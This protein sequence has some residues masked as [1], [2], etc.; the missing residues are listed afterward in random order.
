MTDPTSHA[1]RVERAGC[2]LEGLS[3]GGAFGECFFVN[4][5]AV[6]ALTGSRTPPAAPWPFTDDTQMAL[7]VFATLRGHGHVESDYLAASFA[8]RYDDRRR[9][10]PSMRG[11][12][13]W[14]RLGVPWSVADPRLF[15]GSG[16]HGNGAAMRVAPL[17]AYFAD[18]LEAVVRE[19]EKSAAVT[20]AHPE[21]VAGAVA[22]AVAAA[23]AV[24][25]RA[26]GETCEGREFL[27]RILFHVPDS[28]VREKIRHA[29]NLAPGCSVYLAVAALGNGTQISAQ[30]T[31][32][33]ALWCA[34]QHLNDYEE[35][36][37]LTVRGLGDRD[38]TCAIVGGIVAA[39]TGIDGIPS[40]WR[41]AR[42][43][44][45]EWPFSDYR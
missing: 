8:E 13:E 28:A 31:V 10:G 43:P 33:F 23:W 39:H 45:P 6:S 41:Q 42:E 16:S 24:R 29:R 22:V 25:L 26:S 34:A 14:I 40:A 35:A 3:V 7:S 12:L 18:D 30:D 9:Y 20:H 2:S 17:G 44:L 15:G 27:D 32:P 4:A 38:T 19:A 1:Q 37:W 11:L 36:L 5:N 21:A